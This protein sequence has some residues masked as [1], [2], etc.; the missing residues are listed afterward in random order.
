M[1]L[2]VDNV[3]DE[4][5]GPAWLGYAVAR[6]GPPWRYHSNGG[7]ASWWWREPRVRCITMVTAHHGKFTVELL[8]QNGGRWVQLCTD[9]RISYE[10]AVSMMKLAGIE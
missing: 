4:L 2:T 1:E 5:E 9:Q 8:V 10:E 7:T 6:W 3:I